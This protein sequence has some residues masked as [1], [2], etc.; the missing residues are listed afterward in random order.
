MVI[1]QQLRQSI[2]SAYTFSLLNAANYLLNKV[3]LKTQV[4][5]GALNYR[6]QRQIT[7]Q[8][9]ANST[10]NELNNQTIRFT[11]P[12]VAYEFR[13]YACMCKHIYRSQRE[14]RYDASTLYVCQLNFFPFL[15]GHTPACR[16]V[17]AYNQAP[18]A[19]YECRSQQRNFDDI[20]SGDNCAL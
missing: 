15:P 13:S 7:R 12:R 6:T 9:K 4:L 5:R 14:R 16:F 8:T 2:S 19:L 20:P 3:K 11:T 18:D 17:V 1:Y 10:V